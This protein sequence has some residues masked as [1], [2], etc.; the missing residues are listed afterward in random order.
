MRTLTFCSMRRKLEGEKVEIVDLLIAQRYNI[1]FKVY[2]FFR[3]LML[4]RN[5]LNHTKLKR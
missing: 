1:H 3:I 2:D 4:L 5:L